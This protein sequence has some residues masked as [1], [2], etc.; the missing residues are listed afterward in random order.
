MQTK[1]TADT[2]SVTLTHCPGLLEADW[3]I[4]ICLSKHTS[5]GHP[6]RLFFKY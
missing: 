3:L 5:M 6:F 2:L 1:V 4:C